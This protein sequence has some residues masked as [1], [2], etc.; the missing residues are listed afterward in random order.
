MATRAEAQALIDGS[1]CDQCYLPGGL[2]WYGVLAALIDIGN[3]VT[4]PTAQELAT[5]SGCL[6]CVIPP[7][8]LPYAI[9][10]AL[11]DSGIGGGGGGLSG[12]GSPEGAVL[13]SPGTT[14]YEPATGQFWVK[15]TGTG[16]TTGW[17]LL[18]S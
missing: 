8:L 2:A 13:G 17:V 16:T 6:E 5:E 4:V 7:G 11:R 9:L 14:Y 12:V 3:G 15:G 18:V 1:T 10:A